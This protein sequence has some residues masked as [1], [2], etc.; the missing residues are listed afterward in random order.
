M[1]YSFVKEIYDLEYEDKPAYQSLKMKLINILNE[2]GL[3][4]DT[5]YDWS[6]S[7]VISCK[8]FKATSKRSGDL[9][10]EQFKDIHVKI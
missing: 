6:E 5:E 10:F 7:D 4:C 3:K 8:D 1:F 9:S 2:N